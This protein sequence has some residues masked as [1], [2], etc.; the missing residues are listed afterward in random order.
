MQE[1]S[2]GLVFDL[3]RYSIDDGPGV[4]TVVFMKGCPL[5]CAWCANPESQSNKTQIMYYPEA[6]RECGKCI[7][8]CP[9]HCIKTHDVYGLVIDE[10]K[11]DACG[12]CV[13]ACYYG[14]RKAMGTKMRVDEIMDIILRDVDYYTASG[15]GVTVSGGEPLM[16]YRF[17]EKLLIR[18]KDSAIHTAMETCGYA[19]WCAFEKVMPHLDLIYFDYKHIDA[20]KHAAFTGKDNGLIRENLSRLSK[21]YRNLIVRI[22]Y[23]PG[24]NSSIEDLTAMIKDIR[25]MGIKN[26]EILPYHRF[27]SAKYGGLGKPYTFKDVLPVQPESVGHIIEIG[28]RNHVD[29]KIGGKSS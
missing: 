16:Q 14:A 23:I 7:E 10:E 11:C 2:K 4:R 20:E 29:I 18:C 3:Q 21:G 1:S 9:Q 25:N 15:G 17:V 27:G 28:K 13:D 8:K 19:D 24:F 26:I 22:P 6:C 12:I 5:Q